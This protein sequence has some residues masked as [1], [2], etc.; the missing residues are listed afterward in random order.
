MC[1]PVVMQIWP[2]CMNEPKAPTDDGLLQ[3]DVVHHDE[4]RVSAEFQMDALQVLGAQR[5]H[6]AS[7]RG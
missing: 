2:W 1:R 4:R 3:V 5:A 6:L 7:G